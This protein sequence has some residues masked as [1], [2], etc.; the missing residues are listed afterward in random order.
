MSHMIMILVIRHK[1]QPHLV[2]FPGQ[3]AVRFHSLVKWLEGAPN[4]CP[5]KLKSG[6]GE[7][8]GTMKGKG[9][10]REHFVLTIGYTK[11]LC[12]DSE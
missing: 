8:E 1:S 6:W 4:L 2:C 9:R 12:S 7:R 5:S 11:V 3:W 10:E